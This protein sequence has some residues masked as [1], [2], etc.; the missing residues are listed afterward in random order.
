M[1][2]I[3]IHINNFIISTINLISVHVMNINIIDTAPGHGAGTRRLFIILISHIHI[4]TININ[5]IN[6]HINNYNIISIDIINMNVISINIIDAAP[7]Q[8][9]Y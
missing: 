6:I 8:G 3:H 4:N 7:G 9:A 5:T 2:T 1:N